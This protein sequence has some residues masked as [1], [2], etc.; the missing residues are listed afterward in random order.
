MWTTLRRIAP[1]ANVPW[2]MIGDFNEAKWQHEHLSKTKRSEKRMTEFRRLLNFC[3]MHDIHSTGPPW[4]FNNKQKGARN[5]RARIDRAVATHSWS[6]LFPDAKLRHVVSTRSDHLPLLLQLEKQMPG[7]NPPANLKYEAM[8]EREPSL[9]NTIEDAWLAT[10]GCS[11]LGDLMGKISKTSDHLKE[12][13]SEVFGKV[14]NE[15]KT[16]RKTLENIWKLPRTDKTE[17]EERR[18]ATEL[19]ELLHRE[20]IMWRQRSRINW[21]REGDRNTKYFHTKAS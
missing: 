20:E 14:T 3:N 8:W 13:N 10:P 18:I 4:T 19:D 1:D 15:I 16:R 9:T 21:L 17:K 12:W 11:N 2:M 7:A 6:D 5:V